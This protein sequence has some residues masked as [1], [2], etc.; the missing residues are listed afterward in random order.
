MCGV[1]C[2]VCDVF[3]VC[4]NWCSFCDVFDV[5]LCVVCGVMCDLYDMRVCGLWCSVRDVCV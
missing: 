3:D 5:N 2:S 4:V 1:W